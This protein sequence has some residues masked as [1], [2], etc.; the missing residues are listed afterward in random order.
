MTLNF[1]IFFMELEILKLGV[2]TV[3]AFLFKTPIKL[4]KNPKREGVLTPKSLNMP[5]LQI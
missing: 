4:K 2:G 5:L 1:E 3:G